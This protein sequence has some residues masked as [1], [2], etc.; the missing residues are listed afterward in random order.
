MTTFPG[1]SSH[2]SQ[3]SLAPSRRVISHFRIRKSDN[4]AGAGA[5]LSLCVP[6]LRPGLLHGSRLI[7]RAVMSQERGVS[8]SNKSS[9]L[10]RFAS[11]DSD[12]FND[13][14]VRSSAEPGR[15]P[16]NAWLTISASV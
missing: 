12:Y 4:R 9:R 14:H 6:F 13:L 11:T 7:V 15:F 8:A 3:D 5:V 10:I 1:A 2:G 16:G